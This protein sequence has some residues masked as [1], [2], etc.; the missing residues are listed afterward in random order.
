MIRVRRGAATLALALLFPALSAPGAAAP[1]PEK[2]SSRKRPARV[3]VVQAKPVNPEL[4]FLG[5]PISLDLKDA[6]LKDVLRTFAELA[7]V[8]IVIDPGVRGS[9]T[10]RLYDVPWDQ[11]L[12]VILRVN[13]LGYVLEGNIL[14]IGEPGKLLPRG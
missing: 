1:S 5:E 4:R 2:A 11:A 3:K 12:D 13:G 14:R 9:V 7:K 8:N 6:D 10:I